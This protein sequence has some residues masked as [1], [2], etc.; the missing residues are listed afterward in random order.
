MSRIERSEYSTVRQFRDVYQSRYDQLRAAAENRPFVVEYAASH[1]DS[2][3]RVPLISLHPII[4]P[5][6][7]YYLTRLRAE[8]WPEQMDDDVLFTRAPSDD[9]VEITGLIFPS[10]RQSRRPIFLA[11][12]SLPFTLGALLTRRRQGWLQAY[13]LATLILA[14]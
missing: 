2:R 5:D 4:H 14:L 1:V 10:L 12:L 7:T 13:L 3:S 6:S 9:P 11:T 8:L